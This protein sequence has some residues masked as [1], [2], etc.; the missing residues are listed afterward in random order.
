MQNESGFTR[1]PIHERNNDLLNLE[2]SSIFA[3]AGETCP[4]PNNYYSESQSL[5]L[6]SSSASHAIDNMEHISGFMQVS[7]SEQ[8]IVSCDGNTSPLP[9]TNGVENPAGSP[10]SE[11]YVVD[12]EVKCENAL[13][14][15]LPLTWFS[16]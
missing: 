2:T 14:L 5:V 8:L 6:A 11:R 4:L 3:V 1:K 7:P 16:V 10:R 15:C 13:T 9:D 12:V